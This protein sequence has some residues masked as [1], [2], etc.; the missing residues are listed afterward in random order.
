M[1]S[2]SLFVSFPPGPATANFSKFNSGSSGGTLH[3]LLLGAGPSCAA[4]ADAALQNMRYTQITSDLSHISFVAIFH[5]AGPADHFQIGDPR[6]L[7]QNVVLH[8]ID[9]RSGVFSLLA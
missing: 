4:S 7:G 8:T 5:H 2:I 9:E 6:Q 1:R 3:A